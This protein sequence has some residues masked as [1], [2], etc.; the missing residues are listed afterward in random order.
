MSWRR[1]LVMLA[2]QYVNAISQEKMQRAYLTL[3]NHGEF[4]SEK[5]DLLRGFF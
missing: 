5:V 2:F 4:L 3:R 1:A